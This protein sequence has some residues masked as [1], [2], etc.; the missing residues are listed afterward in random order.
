MTAKTNIF[1]R[2]F[3]PESVPSNKE[4]KPKT[5]NSRIFPEQPSQHNITQQF[6][7]S[8]R[9]LAFLQLSYARVPLLTQCSNATVA[10]ITTHIP[11]RKLPQT[12]QSVHRPSGVASTKSVAVFLRGP[13]A[14][15][16]PQPS[17]EAEK[18][19][20]AAITIGIRTSTARK[21]AA[22]R[23]MSSSLEPQNQPSLVKLAITSGPPLIC[24]H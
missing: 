18:P 3:M 1:P 11:D 10:V 12:S 24:R 5:G 2:V 17:I 6:Y 16:R 22:V 9:K 19:V 4:L 7:G 21:I 14:S 13:H 23:C 15:K 20:F 8:S